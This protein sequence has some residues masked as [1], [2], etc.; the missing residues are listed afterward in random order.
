ML[1]S[2][3]YNTATLFGVPR[4]CLG[5][6]SEAEGS[7]KV[8]SQFG[9]WWRK[10]SLYLEPGLTLQ[11]LPGD[12]STLRCAAP[13]LIYLMVPERPSRGGQRVSRRR[14][15]ELETRAAAHLSDVQAV[16]ISRWKFTYLM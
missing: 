7:L 14:A 15:L 13:A 3:I 8:L 6:E 9:N 1:L 10:P 12:S 5:L 2:A 11:P 4:Y 16:L